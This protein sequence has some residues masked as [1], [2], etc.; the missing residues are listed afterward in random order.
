MGTGQINRCPGTRRR[1]EERG[2]RSN[3]RG[4]TFADM[5]FTVLADENALIGHCKAFNGAFS[6]VSTAF[7]S[8]SKPSGKTF[9]LSPK[10]SV[11]TEI[12][13]W[14]TFRPDQFVQTKR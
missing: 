3:I 11:F 7:A 2:D 6:S 5:L 1:W 10:G 13:K 8:A 12:D 9:D 14:V 4:V